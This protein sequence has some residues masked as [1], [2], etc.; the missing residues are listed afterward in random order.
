[1]PVCLNAFA[2]STL[3]LPVVFA[4]AIA[5]LSCEDAFAP[6]QTPTR[7]VV[8]FMKAV[9][10]GDTDVA[11]QYVWP[12][13]ADQVETW[14][15]ML[16]FPDVSTPPTDKELR[17]VETFIGNMYRFTVMDVGDTEA[18]VSVKFF[19]TDAII[20]Y[21][22]VAEDPGTPVSATYSV[23]LLR[24]QAGTNPQGKADYGPWL[25]REWNKVL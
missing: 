14:R 12:D 7:V 25:I 24:E 20:G 19:A 5:T 16:I 15:Q 11:L 4:L 13:S 9:G 3:L 10:Q 21:P 6:E 18:T 2:R 22:S 23:N 17:D 1:M 8:A